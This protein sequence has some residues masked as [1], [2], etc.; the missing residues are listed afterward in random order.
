[1][2]L[3]LT[4]LG[5]PIFAS[6]SRVNSDSRDYGTFFAS[7]Q[8]ALLARVVDGDPKSS[9]FSAVASDATTEILEFSVQDKSAITA[10]PVDIIALQSINWKNFKVEWKAGVGSYAIVPGF[11]FTVTPFVGTDLI[12]DFAELSPD[13]YKITVTTT[14]VANQLKQLGGFYAAKSTLQIVTADVSKYDKRYKEVLRDITL[15]DGSRSIDYVRRSPISYEHYGAS[16]ELKYATKAERG[17]LRLIKSAGNPFTF[18]PEPYGDP[19]DVYTCLMPGA[20]NDKY[21]SKFTGAGYIIGFNVE[22]VGAL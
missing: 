8:Q 16:L 1:M 9:W 12:L 2:S 20:W 3:D 22:D 6:R 15:G 5:G 13:T 4:V 11:D 10:L 17:A 19:G 14:Q 18:I 7:S 21:A